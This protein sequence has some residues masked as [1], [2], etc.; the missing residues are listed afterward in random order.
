MPTS[1]VTSYNPSIAEII[2]EAYERAGIQT[3]TGHEYITARRSLNLLTLEWANR[4]I[5]LDS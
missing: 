3:M 2:D 5:D 4:G 1:G